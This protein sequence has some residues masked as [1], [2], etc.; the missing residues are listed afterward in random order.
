MKL[1]ESRMF[2]GLIDVLSESYLSKAPKFFLLEK[3]Y[4]VRKEN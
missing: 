1:A 3:Q 2:K 4:D